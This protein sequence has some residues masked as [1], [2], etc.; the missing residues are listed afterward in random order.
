MAGAS[1]AA[2]VCGVPQAASTMAATSSRAKIA[3]KR[4]EIPLLSCEKKLFL[5]VCEF[6]T[7]VRR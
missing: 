2:G 6:M 5:A 7:N 1:V 3:N 4:L